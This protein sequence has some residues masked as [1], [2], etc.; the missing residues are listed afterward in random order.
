MWKIKSIRNT[1]HSTAMGY[2]QAA[3][4]LW[5]HVHVSK[6]FAHSFFGISELLMEEKLRHPDS[7]W[8]HREQSQFAWT[9]FF[10]FGNK[11][12]GNQMFSDQLFSNQMFGNKMFGSA[13]Y[14]PRFKE[15]MGSRVVDK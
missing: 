9:E 10:M 12:F 1:N 14:M 13:N 4:K 6:F 15:T 3:H 2:D 7:T 8:D 11:M 5:N